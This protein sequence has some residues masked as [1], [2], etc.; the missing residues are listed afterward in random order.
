M[1]TPPVAGLLAVDEG[2]ALPEDVDRRRAFEVGRTQMRFAWT[3]AEAALTPLGLEVATPQ[4]PD[5]RG[6]HL[7]L[8]TPTPGRWSTAWPR[9]G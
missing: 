7:A 2:I 3:A 4:D 6:Q 8:A 1:G 5:R 9:T